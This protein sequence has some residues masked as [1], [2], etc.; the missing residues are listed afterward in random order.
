MRSVRGL[1]LS[2]ILGTA[3]APVKT[4]M[5]EAVKV[6]HGEGVASHSGHPS[7]VGYP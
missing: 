5:K 7:C 1:R 3:K 6:R 2:F 4:G